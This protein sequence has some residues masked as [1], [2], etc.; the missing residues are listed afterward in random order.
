MHK[1]HALIG[2]RRANRYVH[3]YAQIGIRRVHTYAMIGIRRVHTH[4]LIGMRCVWGTLSRARW[5]AAAVPSALWARDDGQWRCQGYRSCQRRVLSQCMQQENAGP[6]CLPQF[7]GRM[8]AVGPFSAMTAESVPSGSCVTA[9]IGVEPANYTPLKG[10]LSP[11]LMAMQLSVPLQEFLLK[12]GLTTVNIMGNEFDSHDAMLREVEPPDELTEELC[13]LR[14]TCEAQCTALSRQAVQ[15]QLAAPRPTFSGPASSAQGL[16]VPTG[17]CSLKRAGAFPVKG[18]SLPAVAKLQAAPSTGQTAFSVLD[19]REARAVY[20]AS[21]D[22]WAQFG[23]AGE[24]CARWAGYQS[25]DPNLQVE[26]KNMRIEAWCELPLG[27]LRSAL[28]ALKWLKD[29]CA[30]HKLDVWQLDAA[31]IALWLRS[32]KARGATV[33]HAKLAS[34]R[35]WVREL[36]FPFE[37][38]DALVVQ[39]AAVPALHKEIPVTPFSLKMWVYLEAMCGHPNRFVATICL[40]WV[41]LTVYCLRFAH[42]QRARLVRWDLPTSLEGEVSLGKRKVHG[43]RKPFTFVGPRF[44]ITGIDVLGHLLVYAHQV[45]LNLAQD[46]YM[47]V[48][49]APARVS[50]AGVTGTTGQRMPQE[51]FRRFSQQVF[52]APPFELSP[53]EAVDFSNTYAAR[54]G[55]KLIKK[56]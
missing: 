6:G 24:S 49:F 56:I 38:Q 14:E 10:Q 28:T 17:G 41:C 15:S 1:T 29:F 9:N 30:D 20:N 42:W 44:G 8:V 25:L 2:M 55:S 22:I 46:G 33:P 50:L 3:T 45:S 43:R 12:K 18:Q 34:L 13:S 11:S 35:W 23:L 48:D 53:Q 16:P 19:P 7:P 54:S 27:S 31:H 26:E 36:G 51:R 21:C 40:H 47:L 5:S 52:R 32:L 37:T 39:Q 4:A